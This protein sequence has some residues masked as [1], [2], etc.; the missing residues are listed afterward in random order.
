MINTMHNEYDRCDREYFI[1]NK[2]GFGEII[3]KFWWDKGHK[4]GPEIHNITSTG[5]IIIQNANKEKHITTLIARPNQIKR[6]YDW[7]GEVAPN[8]LLDIAYQHMTLGYNN[9]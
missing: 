2:I 8:W 6:Y 5:L 7:S 1:K 9:I 4:N 3:D